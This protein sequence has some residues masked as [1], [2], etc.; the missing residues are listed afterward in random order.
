VIVDESS[1]PWGVSNVSV[2]GGGWGSE[3]EW[4]VKEK[5]LKSIYVR[6][7]AGGL[8]LVV[9]MVVVLGICEILN[10]PTVSQYLPLSNPVENSS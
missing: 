10:H 2:D 6:L 3:W 1:R 8:S 5:R 7:N 9:F 4:W